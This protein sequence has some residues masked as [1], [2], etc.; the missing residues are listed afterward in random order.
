[1]THIIPGSEGR[2]SICNA[3]KRKRLFDHHRAR[4]G[5]GR[6]E[7]DD[8]ARGGMQKRVVAHT[9]ISAGLDVGLSD[10]CATVLLLVLVMMFES[11][12][13]IV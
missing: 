5:G 6:K 3:W 12:A 9:A 11:R 2:V 4:T 8:D 13:V 10:G 7:S 1:M